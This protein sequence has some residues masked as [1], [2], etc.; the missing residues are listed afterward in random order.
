[1][2]SR[3]ELEAT[4]VALNSNLNGY[5]ATM[6]INFI[7]TAEATASTTI[8]Y[9]KSGSG[10][11]N[12]AIDHSNNTYD[13]ASTAMTSAG[14]GWYSYTY[15]QATS[16]TYSLTI[17]GATLTGLSYAA[18]PSFTK[19][20]SPI[21]A[22]N[23]KLV[24]YVAHGTSNVASAVTLKLHKPSG[25]TTGYVSL[26]A[27]GASAPYYQAALSDDTYAG[28]YTVSVPATSLPTSGVE[29][30]FYNG[31]ANL[32]STWATAPTAATC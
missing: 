16:G 4:N 30:N 15:T 29:I 25:W 20:S 28:W 2:L 24:A 21:S 22:N 10:T 5:T 31:S 8:Y 26:R 13:V 17:D 7:G 11:P 3:I 9:Y 1:M 23:G 32:W 18:S 14:S 19:S 12:I 6:K 27:T